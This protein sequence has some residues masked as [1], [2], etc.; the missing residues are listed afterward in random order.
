MPKRHKK[1]TKELILNEARKYQYRSDFK[2]SEPNLYKKV[3]SNGWA[4]EAFSHM[5][6]KPS[7]WLKD[8]CFN[9]ASKCKTRSEYNKKYPGA[10]KSARNHGWFEEISSR[11]FEPVGN[12]ALRCIYAYE[13]QDG[14]VYVG[15]TSDLNRRDEEHKTNHDSQ[16]YKHILESGLTPKLVKLTEYVDYIK[17]SKL[18]GE[19]L[20]KY[21]DE[22]WIELNKAKTGGLGTPFEP[23]IK[24]KKQP[25]KKWSEEDLAKEAKKYKTRK[26]FFKG[27]PYAYALSSKKGILD[28]ICGHM[29][30]LQ[31]KKWTKQ[32]AH[33]EALKYNS[34]IEFQ[35]KANGCYVI[36]CR[37]GW[38]NEIC[39]H[40]E[41]GY[42]K[43]KIY[44]EE[45]VIET[46]REYTKL[47]ELRLSDDKFVRG[48]Y[49]W[50]KKHKL[51]KD[52][53]KYLKH[54]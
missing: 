11:Y 40:M 26:D 21:T 14:S 36:S 16:V 39:D 33:K 49:W 43:L 15:L 30:L 44:N 7:L 8:A 3:I 6:H 42:E 41:N 1:W 17:A 53:K 48:C 19:Y 37:N 4:N 22:G 12:K 38:I 46:L 29:V 13:F 47:Q 9:A 2:K 34:K 27:S 24:P 52:F 31:R 18:E 28:S 54:E 51:L 32:E 10:S 20:K 35:K 5:L 45:N 25:Q 23:S 50:L